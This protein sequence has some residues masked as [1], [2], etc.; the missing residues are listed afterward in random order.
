VNLEATA[1]CIAVCAEAVA[2]GGAVTEIGSADIDAIVAVYHPGKGEPI[3]C[4][5]CGMCR[6]LI[7]DYAPY[8]T[9]IVSADGGATEPRSISEFLPAK[10]RRLPE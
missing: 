2:I 9:V 10:Y 5:P 4:A 8:A 3:V 6:E 1:G 7:A